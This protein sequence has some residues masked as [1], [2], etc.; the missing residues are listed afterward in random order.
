MMLIVFIPQPVSSEA[1]ERSFVVGLV[2]IYQEVS[3]ISLLVVSLPENSRCHTK[4]ELQNYIP[5]TLVYHKNPL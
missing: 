2:F 1:P 4:A 5:Y 3:I